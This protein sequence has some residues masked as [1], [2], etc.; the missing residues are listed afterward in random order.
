MELTAYTGKL[1]YRNVDFSFVFDGQELRLIPPD[2]KKREI[3]MEWLM[4]PVG[5]GI[6]TFG[7]SLKK[8]DP[9]LIGKCNENKKKMVFLTQTDGGKSD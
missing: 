6:Y 9:F 2:S 8:E 7:S 1:Q 3:E 4:T 5:N